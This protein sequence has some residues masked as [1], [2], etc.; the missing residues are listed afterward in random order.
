MPLVVG[1]DGERLA[2]R[3]GAV[4]LRDFDEKEYPSVTEYLYLQSG[5]ENGEFSWARVPRKP[6][7]W[8]GDV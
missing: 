4:T 8:N 5:V 6:I 3:H 1:E 2:K 7:V